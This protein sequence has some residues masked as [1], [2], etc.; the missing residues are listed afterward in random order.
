MKNR[1]DTARS[2]IYAA[3]SFVIVANPFAMRIV[4][5]FMTYV[6]GGAWNTLNDTGGLNLRGLGIHALLLAII[7]YYLEQKFTS[8]TDAVQ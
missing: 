3:V 2:C 1:V 7:V 5:D 4:N 6:S 8:K